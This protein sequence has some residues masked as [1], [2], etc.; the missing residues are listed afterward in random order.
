[1]ETII[2]NSAS[3]QFR[4][5]YVRYAIYVMYSRVNPDYRDGLK[6]IHRR[7]LWGMWKNSKA[8]DHT[9]KSATVV[10]D[11]MGK[12]HPHGDASV[13][14]SIKPM[15]NWF[16]C[17]LPLID[18]QG[19]FGNLQGNGASASRY[20]ECKLS[21]FG[22]EYVLGDIREAPECVDW[23][24]N[25][26]NTLMEP[27]FLPAAVPL[28]LIN[29]T[30]AIGVGKKPQVPT[31]NLAEVIDATLALIKDSTCEITLVPDHCMPCEIVETDFTAISRT[32]FG[33]YT[34]RGIIDIEVYNK[35]HYAK[36]PATALVIKSV[37]NLIFL[38]S[39]TDKIDAMIEA[40]KIVQI[41]EV[42]EECTE[43]EMRYVIILKPGADPEYVR[44]MIYRNT[45]MEIKDR[46]N[47][48]ALDG[49]NPIR[50]S[51]KGYLLSFIDHRKRT[52]FR[53][54]TNRLQKVQT[55]IFEREAFI[56]ILKSGKV[57]E[58]IAK[59]RARQHGVS[60]DELV[61]WLIK[62]LNITTLQAKYIINIPVKSLAIGRLPAMQKEM[63][64]LCK[65][66][67]EYMDIVTS[68]EKLTQVVVDELLE[69]KAKYGTPRICRI[70]PPD[71]I[72][73][74]PRG[75]MTVV[76]TERNFVK[77]VP[78]GS[79]VGAAKGD[80]IRCRV[81][82]DNTDS[83]LIFDNMGRVFKLPVHKI[84]F[85]DTKS[86]G[87]DVR[88]L[89]KNLN[90]NVASII[91]ES[92]LQLNANRA[93]VVTLTRGGLIK[94]MECSDFASI[95]A[96]GLIYAKLDE[97][98][99]IQSVTLMAND[100]AALVFSDRRVMNLPVEEIPLMKRN[101]KGNKTFRTSMTDGMTVIPPRSVL[102]HDNPSLVVCTE[103]GKFNKIPI[104]SIPDLMIPKKSF[105][106]CKLSKDR[107]QDIHIVNEACNIVVKTLAEQHVIPVS[108][109]PF[110]STISTGTKVLSTQRDKIV[111]TYIQQ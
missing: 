30:F 33:Y 49:L 71:G 54:F 53:V 104:L 75:A 42:F 83:I 99:Y 89:L 41:E 46:V 22:M 64:E 88:F 78:L 91:P 31:H 80:S 4:N 92:M 26:D 25:F 79:P 13:Y 63:Y 29:G 68:E 27:Q 86:P 1:M 3:A 9:V 23:E 65:K 57:D 51:Y 45:S 44:N 96:S 58:V 16:E 6:P 47:F 98:D 87:I 82:L 10:G 43:T 52:K 28:L 39:I 59:L 21:K 111:R 72:N 77:K 60:D 36:R 11:V 55:R 56:T 32:G 48:E 18:N 97:G 24:P 84:G 76:F 70:V 106:V 19:S 107:I 73:E 20:T 35:D 110:G 37:P 108:Q 74:I 34:V 102:D 105:S 38:N 50:M 66:R 69:I 67:D 2:Q 109:I 5:D 15:T 81:D 94:R 8:I 12:Y 40:K 85:A 17:K 103:N 62:T 14:D 90:A 95:S 7:I 61:D 101:S 100:T 93:F